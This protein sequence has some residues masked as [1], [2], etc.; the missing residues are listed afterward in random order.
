[1]FLNVPEAAVRIVALKGHYPK[2]DLAR[3]LQQRPQLML[4]EIA[5]LEN[6][7]K[8]VRHNW[9]YRPSII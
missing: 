5:Q 3:I 1:L 7:A 8:Q 6:N 9:S 4:A 2:A